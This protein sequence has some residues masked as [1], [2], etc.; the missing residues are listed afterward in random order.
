M[1]SGAGYSN[2]GSRTLY[3]AG[4][5]RNAKREDLETA[6]RYKEGNANSHQA[7]DSKDNRTIANK[8]ASE[9]LIPLH[10]PCTFSLLQ[11]LPPL[12]TP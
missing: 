11:S 2:V 12:S 8:L 10:L 6:E 1:S 7:Q 3:E 4:D 9:V 5:Q